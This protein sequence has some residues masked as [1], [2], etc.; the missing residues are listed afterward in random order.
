MCGCLLQAN[1]ARL[2]QT[3]IDLHI[4][5][6]HSVPLRFNMFETEAYNLVDMLYMSHDQGEGQ[7]I[8]TERKDL[9]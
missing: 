5:N 1:H 7:K 6:L 3:H 9:A 4:V 2:L 8:S